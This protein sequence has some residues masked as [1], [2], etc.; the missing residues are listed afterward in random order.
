MEKEKAKELVE[1][2]GNKHLAI[3]CADD[4][5]ATLNEIPDMDNWIEYWVNVKQ[6]IKKL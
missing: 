2:F 6:E 1:S 3:K 5:L 4:I